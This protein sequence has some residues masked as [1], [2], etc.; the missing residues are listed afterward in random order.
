[1]KMP[2]PTK[3]SAHLPSHS[4]KDSPAFAPR[5]VKSMGRALIF[6]LLT[7]LVLSL[8]AAAIAY[9]SSDPEASVGMLALCVAALLSMLG[10]FLTYRGCKQRSLVCGL[11]FGAALALLFWILEWLLPAGDSSW[12]TN[13]RW[14][15]RLGMVIFSIMGAS[16]ASYAPRKKGK[17]N[18]RNKKRKK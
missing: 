17:H 16:L 14:G 9:R 11:A 18:K 7:G 6:T 2:Q 13:I 5:L 3:T 1:M 8:A 4:A 15:L 12:P 10:G